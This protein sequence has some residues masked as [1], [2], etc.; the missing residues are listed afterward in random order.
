MALF[1]LFV[2]LFGLAL[3]INWLASR[4]DPLAG[5]SAATLA[6]TLKRARNGTAQR[7]RYPAGIVV[8]LLARAWLC[9]QLS[10]VVNW[11]PRLKFIL[12]M[13]AFRSDFKMHMLVYSFLGFAE[14][15]AG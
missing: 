5:A 4:H 13:L 14:V 6:G 9:L 7:W 2:N 8:L 11:T 15:L 12:V 10:S 3:W 1:N